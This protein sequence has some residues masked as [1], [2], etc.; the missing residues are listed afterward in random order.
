MPATRFEDRLLARLQDVVAANPE[1]A[2]AAAARRRPGVRLALA[3]AG[4]VAAAAVVT[5]VAA[6]GD[7]QTAAAYD[8]A[9]RADG[10]VTVTIHSLSDAA[11]LQRSLRAAGVPAVV[12]YDGPVTCPAP[13]GPP[14]Q[15]RGAAGA[16]TGGGPA[17]STTERGTTEHGAPA[18]AAK[19]PPRTMTSRVGVGSGTDGQTTFTIDPGSIPAGEHLY[20]TTA[21]GADGGASAVSVAIGDAPGRPC[22]ARP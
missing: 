14:A 22:G 5:L 21:G 20:I 4:A 6:G 1:P 12:S 19:T 16:T 11:G 3:G 15:T 9:P 8:L 10:E 17:P 13:D 7:G 2:R 18:G